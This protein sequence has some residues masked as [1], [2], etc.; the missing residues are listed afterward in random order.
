MN[1]KKIKK[2][3]RKINS[4]IE[5]GSIVLVAFGIY[6]RI[7]NNFITHYYIN[8]VAPVWICISLFGLFF[9]I[10]SIV[11]RISYMKSYKKYNK[12]YLDLVN[13]ELSKEYKEMYGLYF[14]KSYIIS[15]NQ[16]FNIIEYKNVE[17]ILYYLV[18]NVNCVSV[19]TN[20][21]KSIKI[22]ESSMEAC[23]EVINYI[24]DKNKNIKKCLDSYKNEAK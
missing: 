21:N 22:L 15:S 18:S 3:A 20:E 6:S 13:E 17:K 2:E 1:T 4:I 14:T 7:T 24:M 19:L 16:E 5:I 11:G 10:M 23:N 12:E 8:G 9:F